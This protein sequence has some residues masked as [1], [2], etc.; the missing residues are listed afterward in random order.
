VDA[1]GFA[2]SVLT[3]SRGAPLIEGLTLMGGAPPS[4]SG[5]G[6]GGVAAADGTP[7]LI[8]CIIRDNTVTLKTGGGVYGATPA[9][10]TL[11]GCTLSGNK[12]TNGGVGGGAAKN[13]LLEDCLVELNTAGSGGGLYSVLG[14]TGCV[15]RGNSA[16]SNGG[17]VALSLDT[18]SNCVIQANTAGGKGGGMYGSAMPVA[19]QLPPVADVT[20]LQ[21]TAATGGGL[22]YELA[23]P[24]QLVGAS[25]TR[26][27]IA[28][29]VADSANDGAYI[30][31]GGFIGSG[32]VLV[33]N[34]TFGTDRLYAVAAALKI[35]NSIVWGLTDALQCACF[36]SGLQV[37]YSDVKG[38][39]AG[40]GNMNADPLFA[41]PATGDYAL[42]AG[43]PCINKG[44]PLAPHDPDGSVVDMGAIPYD[45]WTDL[46]LALA[47][48]QGEPVLTG[49][50]PLTWSSS[51][52]LE[53]TH[54]A[55]SVA[56]TLVVGLSQ[57]GVPFKGGVMVPHIDALFAGLVTTPTGSL[58]L[59]FIWPTG[60]PSALSV[61][62]QFWLPDPGG[63]KGFAASNG[64]QATSP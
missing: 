59:P 54:A 9:L 14:A 7:T 43:S 23:Q 21:N 37:S 28:D 45:A 40:P 38:G 52:T 26:V 10:V 62:L 22:Y 18:I 27:V 31:V 64:L 57:L 1:T 3:V 32:D 29:N 44:D 8:D 30:D 16:T 11:K 5:N 48:A 34:C 2:K 6:G 17:G 39:A 61:Y 60:L 15:I 49:S 19:G 53:L 55:P 25:L 42:Q 47:G 56:A 24:L 50:G 46:G 13:V 51:N 35:S 20:L 63:P 33:D 4:S 58:T 41:D 36:G 12:V